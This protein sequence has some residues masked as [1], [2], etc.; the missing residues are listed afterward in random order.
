[1]TSGPYANSRF[2]AARED[3][4]CDG[5]MYSHWS[6]NNGEDPTWSSSAEA[7]CADALSKINERVNEIRS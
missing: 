5:R 7:S 3:M 4:V 1:V 2:S 6:F